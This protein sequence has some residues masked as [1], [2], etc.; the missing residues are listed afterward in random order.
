[1]TKREIK[2]HRRHNSSR[3]FKRLMRDKDF[4]ASLVN[5]PRN[6]YLAD[7]E[8]NIRHPWPE[9]ID[10]CT[11]QLLRENHCSFNP[12]AHIRGDQSN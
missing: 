12:L 3:F 10:T 1:M 2:Y 8:L 9:P 5:G 4:F 7:W 6:H 11:F